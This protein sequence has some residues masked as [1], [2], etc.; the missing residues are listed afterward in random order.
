MNFTTDNITFEGVSDKHADKA[1]T[2]IWQEAIA[3]VQAGSRYTIT[4]G[5]AEAE[6]SVVVRVNEALWFYCDWVAIS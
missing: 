5:E 6:G 3:A 4:G 2:K 1:M